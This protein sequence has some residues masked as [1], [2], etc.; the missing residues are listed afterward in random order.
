M[1]VAKKLY[2]G[3]D[4][5]TDVLNVVFVLILDQ[6]FDGEIHT[7]L[8]E[9]SFSTARLKKKNCFFKNDFLEGRS[10]KMSKRR[11]FKVFF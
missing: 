4:V 10:F 2:M 1:N 3:Y 8:S 6:V 11:F 9:A 5:H 7:G